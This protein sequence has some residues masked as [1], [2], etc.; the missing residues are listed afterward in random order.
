MLEEATTQGKDSAG[1][2]VLR[3]LQEYLRVHPACLGFFLQSSNSEQIEGIRS[4]RAERD[5]GP[6]GALVPSHSISNSSDAMHLQQKFFHTV[7][8]PS[9]RQRLNG[10][11]SP[12]FFEECCS[13]RCFEM[14]CGLLQHLA[15]RKFLSCFLFHIC[16]VYDSDCKTSW[17][18]VIVCR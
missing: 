11:L 1:H 4:R 16:V 10:N 18:K 3:F 7:R 17:V 6:Y 5:W 14:F 9:R 15:M 13:C 12:N 2:L 8:A